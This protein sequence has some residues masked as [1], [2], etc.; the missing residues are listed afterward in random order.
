M[1]A[2]V[3]KYSLSNFCIIKAN[4]HLDYALC[5][6]AVTLNM[7]ES[8]LYVELLALDRPSVREKGQCLADGPELLLPLLELSIMFKV[9][10]G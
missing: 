6:C 1:D 7:N 2:P 3:I 5:L 10:G 4:T 9:C 8:L